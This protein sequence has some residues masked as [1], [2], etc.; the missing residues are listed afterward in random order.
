MGCVFL[1]FAEL[2]ESVLKTYQC[3][4]RTSLAKSST[5]RGS[6]ALTAE[7]ENATD[8]KKRGAAVSFIFFSVVKKL[9]WSNLFAPKQKMR[10][11]LILYPFAQPSLQVINETSRKICWTIRSKCGYCDYSS[12]AAELLPQPPTLRPVV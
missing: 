9:V 12:Q 2:F 4:S 8:N 5:T 10:L 6:R 11:L 1:F 7:A 3:S